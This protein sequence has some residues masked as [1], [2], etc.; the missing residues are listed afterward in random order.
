MHAL[1]IDG[2]IVSSGVLPST[3]QLSPEQIAA[4]AAFA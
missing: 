3:A 2:Q 1:I 4:R